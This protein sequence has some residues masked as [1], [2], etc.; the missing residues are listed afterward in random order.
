MPKIR[1]RKA[2]AKRFALTGTGKVRY[3]RAGKSHLLTHKSPKRKRRLDV[4]GILA[5]GSAR[6]V[7]RMLPYGA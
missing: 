4:P 1:T 5:G 7:K 6:A 3:R 2:A